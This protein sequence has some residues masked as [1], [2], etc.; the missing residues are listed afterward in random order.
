MKPPI[1][2]PKTTVYKGHIFSLIHQNVHFSNG[3]DTVYEYCE[4]PPSVSVLAFNTKNEILLIREKRVGYGGKYTWFLP[5]G[6]MDQANDTPKKAALRELREET[7]FAA[8]TM[9]HVSKK[10]PGSTLI[11]DIYTFAAKDLFAS[12]LPKDRGEI[13]KVHFVPFKKAVLMALSGEID[14]EF[15]SYHIIRFDYMLKQGEFSW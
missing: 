13:I 6:R 2:G 5:G 11:W 14:N 12:P 15:I 3:H 8:K 7:G 4:R 9:K 1:L 10:S